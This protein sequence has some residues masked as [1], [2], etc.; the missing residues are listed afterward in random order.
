[1]LGRGVH[2]FVSINSAVGT[3]GEANR[4]ACLNAGGRE[5]EGREARKRRSESWKKL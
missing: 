2:N 4:F 1:V 5:R 3:F